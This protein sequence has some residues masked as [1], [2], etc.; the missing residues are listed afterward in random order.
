MDFVLVKKF[1]HGVVTIVRM[2]AF[3]LIHSLEKAEW[4]T[5]NLFGT[6]NN[7]SDRPAALELRFAIHV[8]RKVCLDIFLKSSV[9]NMAATHFVSPA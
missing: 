4:S 1:E 8:S 6:G 9:T 7:A 3:F 5:G 2:T